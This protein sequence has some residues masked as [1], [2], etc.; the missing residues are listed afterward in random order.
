M[1]AGHP[2]ICYDR[3]TYPAAAAATAAAA[4]TFK[5]IQGYSDFSG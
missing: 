3:S 1:F 4:Q 2:H 5:H